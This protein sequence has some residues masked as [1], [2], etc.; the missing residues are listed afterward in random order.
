MW[1]I[2]RG[3][4]CHL[5][6]PLTVQVTIITLPP[7]LWEI[8]KFK[9]ICTTSLTNEFKGHCHTL[10][11]MFDYVGAHVNTNASMF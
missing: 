11:P 1:N 10:F 9:Y 2:N 7:I 3:S 5:S 6:G 4:F 8:W